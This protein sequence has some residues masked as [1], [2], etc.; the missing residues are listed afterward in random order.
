MSRNLAVISGNETVL[1]ET[2]KLFDRFNVAVAY[3]SNAEE[4]FQSKQ[5]Y[6]LLLL[7]GSSTESGPRFFQRLENDE[8]FPSIYGF[9]PADMTRDRFFWQRSLPMLYQ[10]VTGEQRRWPGT[11]VVWKLMEARVASIV[12]GELLRLLSELDIP[13]LSSVEAYEPSQMSA[14]LDKSLFSVIDE[15]SFLSAL[16]ERLFSEL[17]SLLWVEIIES[18]VERNRC[19]IECIGTFEKYYDWQGAKVSFG[20]EKELSQL[21]VPALEF[22]RHAFDEVSEQALRV[23]APNIVYSLYELAIVEPWEARL[24]VSFLEN[25]L[26]SVCRHVK[27]SKEEA[28]TSWM[29]WITGNQRNLTGWFGVLSKASAYATYYVL[30]MSLGRAI[31]KSKRVEIPAMG[32]FVADGARIAFEASAELTGLIDANPSALTA[33][34][35]R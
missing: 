2:R 3:L 29:D 12:V 5:K 1:K 32:I 35:T 34:G 6:D 4:I 20:A 22:S 9:V 13:A 23:C 7:D 11:E 19:E 8:R 31:Q 21:T 14:Q 25:A 30:I 18:L 15:D 27:A 33:G 16:A 10:R 26:R 17:P 28:P 24:G